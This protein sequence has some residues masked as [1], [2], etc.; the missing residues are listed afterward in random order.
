MSTAQPH[1]LRTSRRLDPLGL[2]NAAPEFDWRL[3]ALAQTGFRLEVASTA[4]FSAST[5]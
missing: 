4:D 5:V 3:D 2:D 1:T